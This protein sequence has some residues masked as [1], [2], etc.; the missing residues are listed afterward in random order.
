MLDFIFL[1]GPSGVGKTTLAK[2]LFAHLRSTYIEQNMVPEFISR[3]GREEMTGELEERT[4][5]ENT[6]AM[7]MCF[8]RLGYRNVIVTDLD[9]LRTAD[10]PVD[11]KGTRYAM[12]RMVCRDPAQLRRQMHGRPAGGLIDDE[13]QQKS[14][15]KILARP[16]QVN[17]LELDVTGLSEA[18]VLQKALSLLEGFEPL[19]EYDYVRPP[20]EAYYSWVFANGLR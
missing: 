3:D 12:L 16:L 10:I 5:W 17:E 1:T 13:L 4:L 18:E 2:G 8:H 9:D 20:K 15:R 14:S 19:E 7:A 6:C 11:F